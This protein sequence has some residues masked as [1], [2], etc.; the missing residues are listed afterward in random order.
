VNLHLVGAPSAQ[1]LGVGLRRFHEEAGA[2]LVSCSVSRC[3]QARER[4]SERSKTCQFPEHKGGVI[5]AAATHLSNVSSLRNSSCE[6]LQRARQL[7][8]VR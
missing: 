7:K 1:P 2:R 4:E 8:G 6:T 5:N 3:C